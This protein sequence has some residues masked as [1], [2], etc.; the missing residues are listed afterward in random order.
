[1]PAGTPR[2][3]IARLHTDIAA[4]M[5]S[6]AFRSE[7]LSLGYELGGEDP[8]QFTAYI[9]SELTRWG[10]VVRDARIKGE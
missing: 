3:V 10:K 2:T 6:P 1:V 4:I 9:K 5:K 8:E 7:A